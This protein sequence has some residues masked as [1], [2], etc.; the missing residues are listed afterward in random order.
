MSRRY[1]IAILT[2]LPAI[3]ASQA[4]AAQSAK[5]VDVELS[6]FKITPATITLDH[7]RTYVFHFANTSKGGHDFVAKRFFAAAHPADDALAR[8]GKVELRG[9]ESTDVEFTAPAAGTYEFHC[10]HLMHST[11]GMKGTITVR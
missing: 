3:A 11:F 5:R 6:N 10:S 4:V 1:A 8:D 2:L 9:G 7:G